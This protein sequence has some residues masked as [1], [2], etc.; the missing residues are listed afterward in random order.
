MIMRKFLSILLS[1]SLLFM[2]ASPLL[3]QSEQNLLQLV[4]DQAQY[5]VTGK[6]TAVLKKQENLE[7]YREIL[8]GGD[9]H[10][11]IARIEKVYKAL[12]EGPEANEQEAEADFD[13][14]KVDF[15]IEHKKVCAR[16]N[17]ATFDENELKAIYD[18]LVQKSLT[19][20]N[21]SLAADLL[22]ILASVGDANFSYEPYT[23]ILPAFLVS[24]LVNDEQ[25]NKFKA[26]FRK[27]KLR[28][29]DDCKIATNLKYCPLNEAVL[30]AALFND[31]APLINIFKTGFNNPHIAPIVIKKCGGTLLRFRNKYIDYN[32]NEDDDL[33]YNVFAKT[34]ADIM[35]SVKPKSRFLERGRI[36]EYLNPGSRIAQIVNA[37]YDSG[38]FMKS[39]QPALYKNDE[40]YSNHLNAWVDLGQ[41]L[42]YLAATERSSERPKTAIKNIFRAIEESEWHNIP[43]AL[44]VLVQ[45]P[46]GLIN[47]GSIRAF[48]FNPMGDIGPEDRVYYREGIYAAYLAAGHSR[49]QAREDLVINSFFSDDPEERKQ[50]EEDYGELSHKEAVKNVVSG[51]GFVGDMALVLAM[52]GWAGIGQCLAIMGVLNVAGKAGLINTDSAWF[53]GTMD[54]LAVGGLLLGAR[55]YGKET[56]KALEAKTPTQLKSLLAKG[57]LQDFKTIMESSS[58][59]QAY[60]ERMFARGY[61]AERNFFY[62]LRLQGKVG[63]RI[64]GLI[65]ARAKQ[66]ERK[67]NDPSEQKPTTLN[68]PQAHNGQTPQGQVGKPKNSGIDAGEVENQVNQAEP[69]YLQNSS[70]EILKVDGKFKKMTINQLKARAKQLRQE[71]QQARNKGNKKLA[72]EKLKQAEEIEEFVKKA[73]DFGIEKNQRCTDFEKEGKSGG[74]IKRLDSGKPSQPKPEFNQAS[75][76]YKKSLSDKTSKLAEVEAFEKRATPGEIEAWNKLCELKT[77]SR[78]PGDRANKAFLERLE[79]SILNGDFKNDPNNLRNLKEF[80]RAVKKL[81]GYNTEGSFAKIYV[82]GAELTE[83]DI[84]RYSIRKVL[85]KI[86]DG[87]WFVGLEIPVPKTTGLSALFYWAKGKYNSLRLKARDEKGTVEGYRTQLDRIIKEVG[88][89]HPGAKKIVIR[90]GEHELGN[91]GELL[92]TEDLH[93]HIEIK[94][95]DGQFLNYTAYLDIRN[96]GMN[97]MRNW[98]LEAMFKHLEKVQETDK[99][100]DIQDAINN[101]GKFKSKQFQNGELDP[102]IDYKAILEEA[103]KAKQELKTLEEQV[104][105]TQEDINRLFGF[106][107]EKEIKVKLLNDLKN[108]IARIKKTDLYKMDLSKIKI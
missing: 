92:M 5:D 41:L 85:A 81:E 63:S 72:E 23:E 40:R 59:T 93:M 11:R 67:T 60:V 38:A 62:R 9:L 86:H 88:Q 84:A 22:N 105:A 13:A 18:D 39:F 37:L 29:A 58:T 8:R 65:A 104:E 53:N 19:P 24:G 16:S 12:T 97:K 4:L 56:F 20:E 15:A 31:F 44:G 35:Y 52:G 95:A 27:R 74:P 99:L 108:D 55:S 21:Y 26:L 42:G 46:R 66:Q 82:D 43:F 103:K 30:Y 34:V 83:A 36:W 10:E 70:G 101:S 33:G 47:S 90:L 45:S 2:Q 28:G 77:S 75:K 91:G 1:F 69:I 94:T 73:E 106:T 57:K 79:E 48:A 7:N 49:A 98:T 61:M 78:I 25:K 87:S 96:L 107:G 89:M 76:N 14:F 51:I 100:K 6:Q 64:R 80:A 102:D 71:S 54:V 17:C 50:A 32:T 3:A 68:D